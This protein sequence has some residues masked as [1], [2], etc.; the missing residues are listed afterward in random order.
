MPVQ[1]ELLL[2]IVDRAYTP[3]RRTDMQ[4]AST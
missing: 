3:L 4:A 1:V 2:W